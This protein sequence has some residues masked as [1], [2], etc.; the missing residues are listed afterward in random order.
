VRKVANPFVPG[1]SLP[2]A[3]LAAVAL[4]K[5]AANCHCAARGGG[6]AYN[7]NENYRYAFDIRRM[8]SASLQRALLPH[9]L[10]ALLKIQDWTFDVQC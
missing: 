6:L 4:A 1:V 7:F 10:I 9:C 3:T 2:T 8:V 5:E